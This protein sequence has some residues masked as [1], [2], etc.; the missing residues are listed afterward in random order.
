MAIDGGQS[1]FGSLGCDSGGQT[2]WRKRKFEEALD[3]R[4]S[5]L[6]RH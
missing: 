1:V 5:N 3:L 2:E 6:K 4:V